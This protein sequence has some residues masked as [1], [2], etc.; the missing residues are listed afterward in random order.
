MHPF[1]GGWVCASGQDRP[2]AGLSPQAL[3]WDRE[4]G[5]RPGRGAA[6]GRGPVCQS[7]RRP[8]SWD[9]PD[10][11]PELPEPIRKVN[12]RFSRSLRRGRSWPWGA[13]LHPDLHS[14]SSVW[15]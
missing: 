11:C 10:S 4:E 5:R 15:T 1:P 3:P 2:R 9:K 14:A 7:G 6:R 13:D 8:C 12:H